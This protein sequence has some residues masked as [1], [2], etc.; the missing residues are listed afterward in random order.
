MRLVLALI[1]AGLIA[2]ILV[3][4]YGYYVAS[5]LVMLATVLVVVVL[6]ARS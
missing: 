3:F 1:L 2:S 4:A 6:A 5:G